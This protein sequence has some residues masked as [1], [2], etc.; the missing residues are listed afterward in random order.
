MKCEALGIL[1]PETKET[2]IKLWKDFY[3][4]Y[5]LINSYSNADDFYLG[6]FQESKDFVNLFCSLGGVR[7]VFEIRVTLYM[8]ALVYCVPTFIKNHNFKEF[9]GQGIGKK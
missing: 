1:F 4:L 7:I 3:S 8:D 9:T 2:V 6:I 5:N